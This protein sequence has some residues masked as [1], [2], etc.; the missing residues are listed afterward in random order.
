MG[1]RCARAE[2]GLQVGRLRAAGC[3][4]DVGRARPEQSRRERA[5]PFTKCRRSSAQALASLSYLLIKDT[6]K[7]RPPGLPSRLLS[8]ARLASGR[9]IMQARVDTG[10]GWLDGKTAIVTAAAQVGSTVAVRHVG[11]VAP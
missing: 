7:E 8:S 10:V 1:R 2:A 6:I 5:V 4:G 11:R 9:S 3:L